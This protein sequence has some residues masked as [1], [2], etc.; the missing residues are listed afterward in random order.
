[1][2]SARRVIRDFPSTTTKHP[3][4]ALRPSEITCEPRA[5]VGMVDGRQDTTAPSGPPP[6]PRWTAWVGGRL[7]R[8]PFKRL[9]GVQD[10]D[11]SGHFAKPATR[12]MD[13]EMMTTPSGKD[14]H[15]WHRA[16][17]R[18]CLDSMLVSETWNVMP[19]VKDR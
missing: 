7:S 14:S 1:M 9:Q 8:V 19:I 10:A 15:A 17:C 5:V 4:R 16:I 3:C 2:L 11:W 18:I 12:L 13:A 6:I